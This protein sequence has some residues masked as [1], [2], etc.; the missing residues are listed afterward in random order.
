MAERNLLKFKRGQC[1]VLYLWR[2][3]AGHQ[4][5]LWGDRLESSFAEPDFVLLFEN[6]VS[7]RQQCSLAAK[8]CKSLHGGIGKSIGSMLVEDV[9]FLSLWHL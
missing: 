8:E 4:G 1:K 7:R 2:N 9:I 3:S 6:R 5:I